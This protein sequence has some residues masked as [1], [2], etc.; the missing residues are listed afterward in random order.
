MMKGS[1]DNVTTD[2]LLAPQNGASS[3]HNLSTRNSYEKTLN[4]L[5]SLDTSNNNTNNKKNIKMPQKR[6][7]E[8]L[9][10]SSGSQ[11]L[12]VNKPLVNRLQTRNSSP[13]LRI[14]PQINFLGHMSDSDKDEDEENYTENDANLNDPSDILSPQIGAVQRANS[15]SN[16]NMTSDSN[17]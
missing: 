15:N 1:N 14:P 7:S 4:T 2:S 12:V 16:N 10:R 6:M 11:T 9:Q 8:L 5:A 3:N 13:A 17:V